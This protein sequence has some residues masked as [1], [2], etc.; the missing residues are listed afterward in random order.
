MKCASVNNEPY[1]N[2]PWLLMKQ[3]HT[4]PQ[5]TDWEEL[6]LLITIVPLYLP[7]YIHHPPLCIRLLII[8]HIQ[9]SII[10]A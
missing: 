5:Q 2:N 3:N 8:L 6:L 7:V 1:Q 4:E 10:T 9:D